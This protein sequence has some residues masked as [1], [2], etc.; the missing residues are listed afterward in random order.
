MNT[1]CEIATRR[2]QMDFKNLRSLLLSNF[3]YLYCIWNDNI[4]IGL[5]I[6]NSESSLTLW[7]CLLSYWKAFM[8][9]SWFRAFLFLQNIVIVYLFLYTYMGYIGLQCFW[10]TAWW[11]PSGDWRGVFICADSYSIPSFGSWWK[12]FSWGAQFLTRGGERIVIIDC[13]WYTWIA[14]MSL[15][16][17]V[18]CSCL[19]YYL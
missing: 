10:S 4:F 7:Y 19:D 16:W 17:L 1:Q 9:L 6:N 2:I 18:F 5:D 14:G 11:L 15:Y 3:Q 13:I 8:F 12:G